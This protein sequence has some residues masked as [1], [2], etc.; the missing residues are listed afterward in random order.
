MNAAKDCTLQEKLLRCAM[1]LIL[2]AGALLAYAAP[3]TVDVSI[4]GKIP[5]GGFATTWMSADGN[6]AY[7]AEPSSPTPAP[8]SYSTS[9]VP[10]GDVTAAIW[11]S[12]GSPGFDASMFPGSWYDGGG[13]VRRG[14]PCAHRLRLLW[15]RVGCHARHERRVRLLGEIRADRRDLRQDEGGRRQGIRRVRGI[16]RQDRRRLSDARELQL[17]HGRSQGRQNG[18]RGGRG[19]P[20]RRLARRRELLRR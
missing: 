19:A 17:V 2:A 10:S 15:V 11:Y 13:E 4:G 14:E 20:G 18:L 16:L 3:S 9:P 1:A 6:I 12:F 5:Y 7:C 8:G